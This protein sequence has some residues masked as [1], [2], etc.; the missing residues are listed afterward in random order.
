MNHVAGAKSQRIGMSR[1]RTPR[2]GP[3][4]LGAMIV[5]GVAERA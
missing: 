1:R 3:G 2:R 4:A 5:G